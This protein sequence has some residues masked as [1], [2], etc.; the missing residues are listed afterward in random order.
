MRTKIEATWIVG[1]TRGHH[2]LLRDALARGSGVARPEGN[3]WLEG[4]GV[5]LAMIACTP[6]TEHRSEARLA[7]A[8]DGTYRLTIGSPEF[9]NGSTTVRHQLAATILGTS[10]DRVVSIS[11][12]TDRAAAT[13]RPR[14]DGTD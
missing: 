14:G 9:G 6:P 11:A 4:K 7:V 5:A 8:R 3:D 2:A 13:A 1:H 10:L 12:D